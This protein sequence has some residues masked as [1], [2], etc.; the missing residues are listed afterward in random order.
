MNPNA[1]R[2]IDEYIAGFPPEVQSLLEKVRAA[3]RKAAP[4]AEEAIKYQMPTYVLN[5]NLIHFAG[6][7]NHI[8]LYPGT[9]PIE[10]FADELAKYETSKGTVKF[11]LDKPIP[12]GLIGRITKFCVAR[13]LEKASSRDAAAKR[14]TARR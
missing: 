14:R 11:P 8:G 13:N 4:A 5:G 9:K 2:N 3:I 1:A 7:K 12:Y 10:A 6:Y